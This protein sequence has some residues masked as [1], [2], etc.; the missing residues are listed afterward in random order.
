MPYAYTKIPAD[1]YKYIQI[2][3]GVLV[4]SDGFDVATGTLDRTKILGA[5][6]GGVEFNTNTEYSDFGE[7]ID[8]VPNNTKQLK[9]ILYYN[10]VF[11]GT[12]VSVN[13]ALVQKLV[14]ASD[15][16]VNTALDLHTV[17]PRTDLFYGS[18]TTDATEDY[19]IPDDFFD[20]WFV[21]DYSQFNSGSEAGFLA[22]RLRNSLSTG[23]FA[24]QTN[25]DEKG[26]FD[27]EFTGH[28]DIRDLEVPFEVY[29]KSPEDADIIP[30]VQIAVSSSKMQVAD[31]DG[32]TS[33]A[34]SVIRYFA[35]TNGNEILQNNTGGWKVVAP[36][37][38]TET[39]VAQITTDLTSESGEKYCTL[40]AKSAGSF[41][42][43]FTTNK[44]NNPPK[45]TVYSQIITVYPADTSTATTSAKEQTIT[46]D[47]E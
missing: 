13:P 5:T 12:F 6:S 29:I 17:K 27:F 21:C 9:R 44:S 40:T 37:S 47:E 39:T 11:S 30:S 31:A 8:N 41:R 20:V 43:Q 16:G 10:P 4:T 15:Y 19:N 26:T 28:Y 24:I 7:D 36:D 23:G 32:N 45:Q 3:A 22:I 25:K 14:A 38:D 34:P 2:N 46:E 35:V 33:K 1:A 42:L 18:S